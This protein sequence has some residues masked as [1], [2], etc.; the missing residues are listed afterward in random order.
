MR[1]ASLIRPSCELLHTIDRES[2]ADRQG[3]NAQ[4]RL[5]AWEPVR[6][7]LFAQKSARRSSESAFFAAPPSNPR[8]NSFLQ[9]PGPHCCDAG[10]G[11]AAIVAQC[12]RRYRRMDLQSVGFTD[13]VN[14]FYQANHAGLLAGQLGATFF[15]PT[16]IVPLLLITHGLGFRILL[17]H[18]HRPELSMRD[19]RHPA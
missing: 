15:L 9:N 13:I 7:S 18:Q 10:V 16:V 19:F 14:A 11:C 4:P 5:A 3:R 17:Q 1:T 6:S 12:S 2:F 8:Q